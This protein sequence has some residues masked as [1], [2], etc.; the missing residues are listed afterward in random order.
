MTQGRIVISKRLTGAFFLE[1]SN[2]A[3]ALDALLKQAGVLDI[4]GNDSSICG[5]WAGLYCE[6]ALERLE[7]LDL[8]ELGFFQTD[9]LGLLSD[10]QVDRPVEED[11]ALSLAAAFRDSCLRLSPRA[12]F[13]TTHLHQDEEWIRRQAA[14]VRAGDADALCRERFGLLYLPPALA[15]QAPLD[16]GRDTLPVG[17]GLLVFAGTGWGRWF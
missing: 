5:H 6:A 13:I 14:R 12:A 1:T 4:K 8:L 9:F 7:S 2:S 10:E 3:G 11:G 16:P 17:D 15:A